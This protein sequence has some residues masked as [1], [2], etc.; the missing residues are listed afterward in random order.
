MLLYAFEVKLH[1]LSFSLE[2]NEFQRKILRRCHIDLMRDLEPM[3]VLDLLYQDGILTDNDLEL[4]QAEKTV[5]GRCQVLLSM[6]PTRGPSAYGSFQRA[7][8][9]TNYSHLGNLLDKIEEKE[10]ENST[11]LKVVLNDISSVGQMNNRIK[12]ESNT[13]SSCKPCKT[14]LDTRVLPKMKATL[15]VTII[16]KHCC[17]LLHNIEPKELIDEFYQQLLLSDDQCERIRVAVTRRDRC[18]IFIEELIKETSDHAMQVLIR[19][20]EKKYLYIVNELKPTLVNKENVNPKRIL[21][22]SETR[23]LNE[24]EDDT[25]SL[26]GTAVE[27]IVTQSEKAEFAQ[28]EI[29]I[30]VHE[31]VLQNTVSV[32]TDNTRY[33]ISALERNKNIGKTNPKELAGCTCLRKHVSEPNGKYAD[34][35]ET[36]DVSFHTN[37]TCQKWKNQSICASCS[38]RNPVMKQCEKGEG[39]SYEVCISDTEEITNDVDST[40]YMDQ[41]DGAVVL[42]SYKADAMIKHSQTHAVELTAD[43]NKVNPSQLKSQAMSN[44]KYMTKKSKSK[45]RTNAW[46]K[47]D[48]SKLTEKD[49]DGY[50]QQSCEIDSNTPGAIKD[51][52][53][54]STLNSTS[55][56][57]PNKR[58]SFAFNHLSTLINEGNF[59][60]FDILSRRLEERFSTDYDMLCIVGYLKTSRDLFLTNF[61][62]A[63]H[64]INSTMELVPKTSNPRYFTLELFTAK[65][66]MYITQKKLEKLQTTLDDAMMILETDPVGCTGRAAG[67]LYINDARN[68]TAKLSVLNL[69]KPNA[70]KIYEQL[71]ERAKSSFKRSMT[72][73]RN[74][75]GKDGP[76]GFGYALCR[77]VILLLRCGDNGMTMN[78]LTPLP[79]DVDAAEHYLKNLEDSEIPMAKILEMH[80]RLAKCD[81]YFRR[82]NKVRALEHADIA[83]NLANELNLMEFKEH[84]YN[85]LKFLQSRTKLKVKEVDDD[86][87]NEILFGESTISSQ[88]DTD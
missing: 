82:D 85:R 35:K 73:F 60:K 22:L 28:E 13:P 26:H 27:E 50:N 68:Q 84:A 45:S 20:L 4:V 78:V 30:H 46:D 76:F 81:Y 19:S 72:N 8:R 32:G 12:V 38:I 53:Q 11:G 54:L 23:K 48:K 49:T 1:S 70:L 71:Y 3:V 69:I 79:E 14:F 61:D 25:L 75:G 64:K 67:W 36:K 83:Y 17:L 52:L 59:E 2:M 16:C 15:I 37:K 29:K 86:E 77:L 43:D 88:S 39:S 18:E 40:E 9:Q 80:F 7:L 31:K 24:V 21:P 62:S 44:R 63:K 10:A 74:D 47:H 6:L 42:R 65:T 41:P 51:T 66:R 57:E 58:L 34:A 87:V 33:V 5:R 55:S 56:K